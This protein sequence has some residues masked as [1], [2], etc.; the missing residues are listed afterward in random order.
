MAT[1]R[2]MEFAVQMTCQS[3][4]SKVQH[5]L[6]SLSGLEDQEIKLA[7]QQV[8]VL[9]AQSVQDVEAALLQTGLRV[10]LRGQSSTKQGQNFGCAVS[11]MSGD[12]QGVVR[13]TQ[14]SHEEV[15]VEGT[16]DGL[17][18][19]PHGLHIHEFGD[20]SQGCA[21]TG[22]HFNPFGLA[23]GAPD[24]ET[25]HVGD[26]GNIVA[27]ASGRAKFLLSDRLVKVWDIIG[28]ALVVHAHEDDLGLSDH[29]D[30]KTT[31]NAGSRVG[32]GIIARSAGVFENT[33]QYCACDGRT[34]WDESDLARSKQP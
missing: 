2:W 31:G 21:S 24:S 11:I 6:E 16:I 20:I 13:F 15:V 19:G 8:L 27:D 22:G 34:L 5:A 32:C 7:T 23:H 18:P 33:K 28:R 17:A 4:V 10:T 29:P 1:S 12:V 26:L 30:S 14:I 9:T 3:C 25:R